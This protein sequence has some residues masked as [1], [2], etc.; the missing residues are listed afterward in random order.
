MKKLFILALAMTAMIGAGFSFYSKLPQKVAENAVSQRSHTEQVAPA[1]EDERRID[2]ALEQFEALEFAGSADIR[3]IQ[4]DNPRLVITGSKKIL[5]GISYRVKN[6]VLDISSTSFSSFLPF[7]SLEIEVHCPSLS[8]VR[9]QGMGDIECDVPLSGE[10]VSIR[11]EG[12]GDFSG[13][14][15]TK[16]LDVYSAGTGDI[17]VSGVT[18]RMDA[19]LMGLGDLMAEDLDGVSAVLDIKGTGDAVLGAFSDLIVAQEG[20]GTVSYKGSPRLEAIGSGH[21]KLIS[22]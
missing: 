1:R 19:V 22:R 5:D 11:L 3:L 21:G 13:V 15:Q 6:G 8:S 20:T 7:S 10:A 16:K 12:T 14:V 2:V 18:E 4:S 9:S 17:R